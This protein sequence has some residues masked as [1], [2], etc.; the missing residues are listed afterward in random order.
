MVSGEPAPGAGAVATLDHPL[1]VDL[2]DDLAIAG[3]Q[4]L[5]RAHFRAQRQ[6]AFDQA[7]GAVFFVVRRRVLRLPD[8][9][10]RSNRRI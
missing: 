1:L 7:V 3:E 6:L 9:N 2:G 5:G 8:L 10:P 4:R